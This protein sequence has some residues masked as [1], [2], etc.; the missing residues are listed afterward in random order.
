MIRNLLIY[1]LVTM[2]LIASVGCVSRYRLS[3]Y[4]TSGEF[5]SKVKV[6]QTEF[7]PGT[8]LANPMADK[9]V[10]LGAGSTLALTV[11]TRGES[12]RTE[13]LQEFMRFDENL[14]CVLFFQLPSTPVP[15]RID[16]EG[17]S[18]VHMLGRYEL[19]PEEKIFMPQPGGFLVV[20]SVI[21]H[22]LYGTV[23]SD[24]A[25]PPGQVLNFTGSF[26]AKIAQ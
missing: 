20:D 24:F 2:I 9:K 5:S 8:Q 12:V 14:A 19:Q 25:N 6:K 21:K 26:K 23:S 7:L 10:I 16:L 18:F 11:G 3:L 1:I 15:D 4:L 17:N 22:N 13:F